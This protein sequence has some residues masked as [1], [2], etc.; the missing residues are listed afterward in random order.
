MNINP[1]G[2]L[3]ATIPVTVTNYDYFE[4]FPIVNASISNGGAF[5]FDFQIPAGGPTIKEITKVTTTAVA[6]GSSLTQLNNITMSGAGAAFAYNATGTGANRVVTPIA[7]NNTNTI[8]FSSTLAQYLAFRQ[9][10]GASAGPATTTTTPVSLPAPTTTASQ[11]PTEIQFYFL[12]TLSDGTT[13]IPQ[14][15]RVRV[16]P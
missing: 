5:H 6:A 15:A 11:T 2:D 10:N 16:Q 7:G 12:M 4:R 1:L 14:P 9:A 13:I 8:T 3:V